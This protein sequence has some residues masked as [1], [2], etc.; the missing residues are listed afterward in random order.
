MRSSSDRIR[1]AEGARRALHQATRC[2][3][4]SDRGGDRRHQRPG[5]PSRGHT[6]VSGDDHA[7]F[8]RPGGAPAGW[9]A[10]GVFSDSVSNPGWTEDNFICGACPSP[11][12]F[13]GTFYRTATSDATGDTINLRYLRSFSTGQETNLCFIEGGTGGYQNLHGQGTFTFVR[14]GPTSPFDWVCTA[15]LQTS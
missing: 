1:Q 11:V 12:A 13:A 6:A 2:G 14:R 15:Q 8:D 5:E 4:R 7:H 3:S 9:S 10:S